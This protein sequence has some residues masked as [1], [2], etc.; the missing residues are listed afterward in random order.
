[1]YAGAHLAQKVLDGCIGYR[2]AQPLLQLPGGVDETP[3]GRRVFARHG[4]RNMASY[5]MLFGKRRHDGAVAIQ[6]SADDLLQN[7]LGQASEA[8]I[9]EQCGSAVFFR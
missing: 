5:L 2:A 3:E 1:M 8:R 9:V 4:V 7:V 6:V